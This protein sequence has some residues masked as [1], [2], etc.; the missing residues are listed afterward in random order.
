MLSHYHLNDATV[1]NDT[2]GFRNN[3]QLSLVTIWLDFVP[4]EMRNFLAKKKL[5]NKC[6]DCVRNYGP[7]LGHT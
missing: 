5:G 1:R 6:H 3:P 4:F 2:G 7:S